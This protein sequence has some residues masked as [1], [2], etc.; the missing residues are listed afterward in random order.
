MPPNTIRPVAGSI[1]KVTGK[2]K[3]TPI[4]AERP[5]KQPIVIPSA[6]EAIMARRF[7][8]EK[9]LMK[10]A[11]IK[12]KVSNMPCSFY[13]K[14][15]PSGRGTFRKYEKTTATM[16]TITTTVIRLNFIG[17]FKKSREPARYK[18]VET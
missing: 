4:A 9:A 2:S 17:T 1:P 8:G 3:A 15:R 12:D 16:I 14:M 5:G 18:T 11:P 13:P 7:S 6:V 10:P